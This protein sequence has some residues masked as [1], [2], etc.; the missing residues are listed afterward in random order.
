MEILKGVIKKSI[1]IIIPAIAIAIYFKWEKAPAGILAGAIFG[2]L[3]LRGLVRSV[4]GFIS[5]KRVRGIIMFS[6]AFRLLGLFAV[7]VALVYLKAVNV[8]GLLFGFTIV[9]ILILIEGF[10]VANKGM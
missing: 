10:R 4:E 5:S 2:I 9:F 1:I 8:F 7:I 6:S 3:N